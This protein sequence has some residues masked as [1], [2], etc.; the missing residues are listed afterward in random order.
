[1]GNKEKSPLTEVFWKLMGVAAFVLAL[2]PYMY[3][4][5]AQSRL[6]EHPALRAFLY[7][8]L[9]V[10]GGYAAQ[11]V[12]SLLMKTRRVETSAGSYEN[13]E[14]YFTFKQG[15]PAFC[16]ALAVA[17]AAGFV[18][19]GEI[20]AVPG[21]DKFS[22]V[23]VLFGAAVFASCAI[24]AMLWFFP[25]ERLLAAKNIVRYVIAFMLALIL[26]FLTYDVSNA[27]VIVSTVLFAGIMAVRG[28]AGR[29]LVSRRR[30]RD[31][32]KSQEPKK[33]LYRETYDDF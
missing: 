20:R 5:A 16:I 3:L 4:A 11:T 7:T 2:F 24:G 9:C 15:I 14:E 30:K 19:R 8:A 10:G 28:V 17:F 25:S 26:T 27:P 32:Q 31:A 18:M 12:I 6:Y 21:F 22:V 13:V 29:V 23:P 1:M 33:E